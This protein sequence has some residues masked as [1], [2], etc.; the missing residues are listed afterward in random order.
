VAPIRNRVTCIP[1]AGRF[2]GLDTMPW[3]R[4]PSPVVAS[5]VEAPVLTA[6]TV[7]E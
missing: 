2:C 6:E 1:T 3:M 7:T 4:A 5:K